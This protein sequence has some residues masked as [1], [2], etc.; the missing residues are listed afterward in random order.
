MPMKKRQ[1]W[2]NHDDAAIRT[3]RILRNRARQPIYSS[4]A[5][6]S[7]TLRFS[8]F[9]L[10]FLLLLLLLT[11]FFFVQ[12]AHASNVNIIEEAER[13]ARANIVDAN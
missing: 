6:L 3:A 7:P 1:P 11:F 12:Y 4:L 13:R 8:G 5:S 10:F 2:V 9:S